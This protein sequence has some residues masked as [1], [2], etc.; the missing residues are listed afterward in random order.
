M[1]AS[2]NQTITV[3]EKN[4]SSRSYYKDGK[5]SKNIDGTKS[6]VLSS[7]ANEDPITK[8]TPLTRQDFDLSVIESWC[9]IRA[10]NMPPRRCFHSSWVYKSFIYIFGGLDILRGKSSDFH[11]IDLSQDEPTWVQLYPS[12]EPMESLAYASGVLYKEK[13]YIIAG[14]KDDLSQ[15]NTIY[16]FH[17]DEENIQRLDIAEFPRIENHSTNLYEEKGIVILFGG[18]SKGHYLNSLYTIDLDQKRFELIEALNVKSTGQPSARINHSSLI[19]DKKLYVFGGKSS[20]GTFLN[21]MWSFDLE[22]NAW[23]KIITETSPKGR[24]GHSMVYYQGEFY[25]FGGKSGNIHESNEL[26]KF[27]PTSKVFTLVHDTLLEQ[28]SESDLSLL[29]KKHTELEI[30]KEK[31]EKKGNTLRNETNEGYH[32]HGSY[33]EV[34][35]LSKLKEKQATE[36]KEKFDS[37]LFNC[38][39]SANL[40]KN[41][42]IYNLELDSEWKKKVSQLASK[43]NRLNQ[44]SI[45]AQIPAPRDGHSALIYRNYMVIFGGDRNKFPFNDLFTFILT[46]KSD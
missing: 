39:P 43:S 26:W 18:F 45:S 4:N 25:I 29:S 30:K 17:I 22:S 36:Q 35:P 42:L 15:V 8:Y 31:K 46:D 5:D 19:F 23:A 20:D 2:K 21:D 1:S 40:M 14:Q 11:K 34:I 27:N 24:S 7:I 41:S 28:F 10:K 32:K 6:I 12:G 33:R 9:E 37:Y 38:F 16:Q 13:Y 3:Q 44:V